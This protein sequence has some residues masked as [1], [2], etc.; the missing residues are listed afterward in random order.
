MKSS[1]YS[2]ALVFCLLSIVVITIPHDLIAQKKIPPNTQQ[3][4]NKNWR[5]K[6]DHI[7][8]G[9]DGLFK[10]HKGNKSGF[11]DSQGELITPVIYDHI[12]YIHSEKIFRVKNQNKYGL[13]NQQ[14]LEIAPIAYDLIDRFIQGKAKIMRANQYGVLDKNGRETVPCVYEDTKV[15]HISS[16]LHKTGASNAPQLIYLKNNGKWAIMKNGEIATP[17]E[18]EMISH[19]IRGLISITKEGKKGLINVHLEEITPCIYD[20]ISQR[21]TDFYHVK[22]DSLYGVMNQRGEMII[23]IQ[24]QTLDH[25]NFKKY[26]GILAQKEN[27]WGVIDASNNTIIPFEYELLKSRRFT[28]LEFLAKKNEKYGMINLSQETL[29]PFQ[30]DTIHYFFNHLAIAH[31][32]N[33]K[34]VIDTLGNE[35]IPFTYDSIKLD[36]KLSFLAAQKD[37]KWFIF[38]RKG[39]LISSQTYDHIDHLQYTNEKNIIVRVQKNNVWGMVDH[40]FNEIIP[41]Q[42]QALHPNRHQ[43]FATAK[44]NNKWGVLD[45]KGKPLLPFEYDTVHFVRNLKAIKTQKNGKF[46]LVDLQGNQLLP[47][48]YEELLDCHYS[49]G[50]I[51]AKK[52]GKYGLL[53]AETGQPSISFIYDKMGTANKQY[54]RIP[55]QKDGKY[56]YINFEEKTI[57]PFIADAPFEFKNNDQIARIQQNGKYGYINKE[58]KIIIPCE[59]EAAHKYFVNEA[60]AVKKNGK[61]GLIDTIGQALT[62]F[63][64]DSLYTP[65]HNAFFISQKNNQYGLIQTEGKVIVPPTY[66]TCFSIKHYPKSI[67]F[68]QK[69]NKWGLINQEGQTVAPLKYDTLIYTGTHLI[70]VKQGSKWGF[71]NKETGK[72]ITP[73][74]YD[75]VGPYKHCIAWVQKEGA[76]GFINLDGE[77]VITPQYEEASSFNDP[78]SYAYRSTEC[79]GNDTKVHS[80]LAIVKKNGKKGMINQLGETIIPIEYEEIITTLPSKTIESVQQ[81]MFN[82]YNKIVT[83]YPYEEHTYYISFNHLK[84]RKNGLSGILT[85]KGEVHIPIEYQKLGDD[86]IRGRLTWFQHNNETGFLGPEGVKY[87][88][89]KDLKS[90][91]INDRIRIRYN[92]KWGFVNTKGEIII[93][94]EYDFI[95]PSTNATAFVLKNNKWGIIDATGKAITPIQYDRFSPNNNKLIYVEQNGKWGAI[96]QQGTLIIPIEYDSIKRHKQNFVIVSKKDQTMM[97]N[98]KGEYIEAIF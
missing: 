49:S 96:N 1:Y 64:Y 82:L 80:S 67:L 45:I 48:Q 97:L 27:K 77:E 66:D 10:V 43:G 61:Y 31:K 28:R 92:N 90:L 18:Y 79:N 53:N 25:F 47:N 19:P 81:Y 15:N 56:G 46:G 63:E 83:S 20:N 42:Y 52:E 36:K 68:V 50:Y 73:L 94:F 51:K 40:A 98:D 16:C 86:A 12:V 60:T 29:I 88:K 70:Q 8:K 72:E 3:E 87:Q 62:A 4:V 89:L 13:L 35:V 2:I 65:K 37:Q 54:D 44:K 33:K 5:S 9:R 39:T 69:E 93:P 58:G 55:V 17:F 23:P 14:G 21:K 34:G 38:N 41:C 11:V 84:V 30:F 32:N 6:Y 91:F 75:S 85:R 57:I 7:Q 74:H 95:I 59:Y 76:Y 22:K 71:L 26:E 24:Y 78:S